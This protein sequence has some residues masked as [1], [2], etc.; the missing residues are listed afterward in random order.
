MRRGRGCSCFDLIGALADQSAIF[1]VLCGGSL[2]RTLNVWSRA[3]QFCFPESPD[4]SRDEVERNITPQLFK[5]LISAIHWINDY[6][7]DKCNQN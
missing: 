4:F 6:P 3:R 1:M 7:T 2:E 5:G